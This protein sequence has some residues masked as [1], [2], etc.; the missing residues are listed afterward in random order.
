MKKYKVRYSKN[1]IVD[2]EGITEAAGEADKLLREEFKEME[3]DT[4][5]CEVEK[6]E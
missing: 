5:E 4:F 6:I 1:Y 3:V 2:A